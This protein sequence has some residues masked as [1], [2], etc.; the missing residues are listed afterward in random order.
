MGFLKKGLTGFCKNPP[1]MAALLAFFL[2]SAVLL[3]PPVIGV[4]DNGEFGRMNAMGLYKLDRLE[5]DQYQSYASTRYG[6]YRYYVEDR[7]VPVTSQ[8]AF[9]KAAMVLDRLFT[10]EDGLFDIRFLGI[11]YILYACAGIYLLTAYAAHGRSLKE[12]YLLAALAVFLFADTGYTAFFNSFYAQGLVFASFLTAAAS[13]LLLTQ[14][15]G[16]FAGLLISVVLNTVILAGTGRQYAAAGLAA[17][18]MLLLLSGSLRG[19]KK[20]MRWEAAGAAVLCAGIAVLSFLLPGTYS[21]ADQY[22]AMARGVMLESEDPEEALEFFDMYGQYALLNG[23]DA[24]QKYPVVDYQNEI[25]EE[26]FYDHYDA[27]SL[28]AYYLTHPGAL[29]RMLTDAAQEGYR[30]R[31]AQL[32]NYDRS[33]GLKPGARTGFFT[34]YSTWKAGAVPA[35]VGFFFIWFALVIAF[36][37]REKEKMIVL[38]CAMLAGFSQIGIAVVK[39]GNSNIS[40]NV[41]LYNVVFDVVTYVSIAA[42]VLKLAHLINDL[43]LGV[44][45]GG[46]R[47]NKASRT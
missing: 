43:A 33:A 38:L 17:V 1:A 46:R 9:V 21:K 8:T 10:G 32:G 11:L 30:I 3:F 47:R 26:G 24:Y 19:E 40:S 20:K 12:G 39:A 28:S 45:G 42:L 5:E 37:F 14:R 22:H 31:P 16:H 25:L 15:K 41:F 7:N 2:M 44:F 13:A 35:T 23:T 6:V 18:L 4:A 36:N 29:S 27:V 34:V